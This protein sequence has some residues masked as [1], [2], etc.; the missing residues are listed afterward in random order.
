[1]SNTDSTSPQRWSR[2]PGLLY[3]LACYLITNLGLVY[4]ILFVNNLLVPRGVDGPPSPDLPSA[5]FV[6]LGLVLLWGIQHS[7]MA[8]RSF[9]TVWTKV[10]PPYTERATY[11]LASAVAL[12]A[13]CYF[14]VPIPDQAWDLSASPYGW[15][16]A[17]AG[18]M[19]W[20]LL[21]LSTFEIDHFELFGIKQAWQ[22]FSGTESPRERFQAK[23]I[24]AWIRHPIQTG[25]LMG[26]WLTPTMSMSRLLFASTMTVYILV[27]LYF[28]ERDLIRQFGD[29]Y[30]RYMGEVARLVPFTM[31][32]GGPKLPAPDLSPSEAPLRA[33]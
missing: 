3:A 17:A 32:A 19:G 13:V 22:A 9:K 16:L 20:A 8:R 28:E 30:V 29:R 12:A 11:C 4:M 24:Y 14:W 26:M 23:Y 6:N 25:I 18:C 27:G 33:D 5:L 2:L 10:I 7:G 21:L 15:I 31:W 1:M